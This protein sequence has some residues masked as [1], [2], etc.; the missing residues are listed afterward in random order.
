MPAHPEVL[1]NVHDGWPFD[2]GTGVV[3]A[4]CRPC[5]VIAGV[6]TVAGLGGEVDATDERHPVVDH[7]RLLVMAVHRPLMRVEAALDLRP[8]DQ[9]I[10]HLP[11]RLPRRTEQRQ[12]CPG[13]HEHS[14]LDALGKVA[15][16][17]S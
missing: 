2:A 4:D 13:P 8:R 5:R 15:P 12:R 3:P 11:H 17:G 6:V 14:H 16:T 9:P 10:P 1:G 7:D